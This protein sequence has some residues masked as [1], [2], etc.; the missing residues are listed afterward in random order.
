MFRSS[1]AKNDGFQQCLQQYINNH[2]NNYYSIEFIG[3]FLIYRF[4]SKSTCRKASIK[5]QIP[6]INNTDTKNKT[7]NRQNR[8]SMEGKTQYKRGTRAKTLN[9]EKKP[10]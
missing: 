5:T 1:P 7:L 3:Y 10:I 2:S 4:N 8:N 6:H 9:P